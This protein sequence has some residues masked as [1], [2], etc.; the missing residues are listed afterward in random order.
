MIQR[1]FWLERIEQAWRRRSIVWLTGVRRAGKTCLC[2][3][4][5][6]VEYFDCELPRI[7][8]QLADPETLLAKLAGKRVV[9]DEIHRLP[10]PSELLKIAADHYPRVKIIATGSSRLSASRKFKDTLTGRKEELWLRPI[11]LAELSAF[12]IPDVRRRMLRG[13]LPPFVMAKQVREHDF[14]EWMDSYWA[15]D[16]QELFRLE[17]RQAFIRFIELLLAQSGGIFE[18]TAFARPCEVN[19]ATIVNYLRV[20][21]ETLVMTVVRPFSTRRATEIVAAPK[22]YGF[23]TG[24]VCYYRGWD[25]LRTDDLG[26]L[27]EHL[28]LNELLAALPYGRIQYWRDKQGHEI[29]FVLC[30]RRGTPAAIECKWSMAGYDPKNL[31]IFRSRYPEGKNFVV[32][33]GLARPVTRKYGPHEVMFTDSAGLTAQLGA[34]G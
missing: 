2:Q 26:L 25:T 29:D 11:L 30:S 4:F 6:A 8:E 7:R 23:D 19:R 31:L 5:P 34:A 10:N 12:R 3:S 22:V 13:G 1:Q 32:A 14:P 24:F 21:E 9:L 33:N 18:A 17:R 28:V 15:K 16:I 27:W 20:L